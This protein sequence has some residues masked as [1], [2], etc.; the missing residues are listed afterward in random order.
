[1]VEL[2]GLST[3]LHPSSNEEVSR[4]TQQV[5]MDRK[6]SVWWYIDVALRRSDILKYLHK[7]ISD[8]EIHP[9]VTVNYIILEWFGHSCKGEGLNDVCLLGPTNVEDPVQL[10]MKD[11]GKMLQSLATPGTWHFMCLKEMVQ[12]YRCNHLKPYFRAKGC[13]TNTETKIEPLD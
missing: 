12:T 3:Q 10:L 11:A 2:L 7:P 5:L 4:P 6:S 9:L 1:M 8:S 13:T